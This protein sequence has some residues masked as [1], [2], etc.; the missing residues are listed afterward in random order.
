MTANAK[1]THQHFCSTHSSQRLSPTPADIQDL[2]EISSALFH[3]TATS[4]NRLQPYR[5]PTHLLHL[6]HGL[7]TG[8][9]GR[10]AVP[11]LEV[12]GTGLNV[13]S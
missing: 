10:C 12:L 11:L 8:L 13:S 2:P 6:G 5:D 3:T 7:V 9:A 1:T 4:T